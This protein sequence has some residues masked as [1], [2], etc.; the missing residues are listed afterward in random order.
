M[1]RFEMWILGWI[2][3]AVGIVIVLS[4]GHLNPSWELRWCIRCTL[5]A[6]QVAQR[7]LAG[8]SGPKG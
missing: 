4:L 3:I 5:R 2:D 6:H 7:K 1:N 8:D